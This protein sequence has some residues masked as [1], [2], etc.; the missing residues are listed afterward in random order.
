MFVKI[1][2]FPYR[3]CIKNAMLGSTRRLKNQKHIYSQFASYILFEIP[4][5][6]FPNNGKSVKLENFKNLA[7]MLNFVTGVCT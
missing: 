3:V 4:T 6:H 5:I 7:M 2:I 1:D